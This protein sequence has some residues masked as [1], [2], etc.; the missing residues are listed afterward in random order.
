MAHYQ[1]QIDTEPKSK[2]VDDRLADFCDTERQLQVFEAVKLHGSMKKAANSLGT[3]YDNV[4]KIMRS[5][6]RKAA[7]AGYSPE[8]SMTKTV[9]DGYKVKGVSSLYGQNGELKAQWVKSEQDKERQLEIYTE[10]INSLTADIPERIS[11]PSPKSSNSDLANLYTIT[12]YHIGMLA[13]HK[14][15]GADWDIR[16]AIDTLKSTFTDMFARSP[17]ADTAIINQLG[18]FLHYDSMESVTPTNGHLLDADGRPEKMIK[19]GIEC[20]DYMITEALKTHKKVMVVCAQGNHDTYSSLFM[21]SMFERLYRGEKRVEF[22]SSQLP[23]YAMK[24]GR[25]MIGFHHGHKVKFDNLPAVFADQ[26]REM[27]GSTDRTYI[28]MGHYHHKHIK[29]LGKTVV[30]MHRTLAARDAYA[31]YGGYF[32]QRSADVITYHK[33]KGEC[34]RVTVHV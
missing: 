31:S 11:T 29:E 16:I 10:I 20:M 5:I 6:R 19:A 33:E 8:H 25:S 15:G 4:K 1:E 12:D 24:F 3:T 23:F 7:N 9:P 28:H 14:E 17:D 32:S 22:V 27:Y 26:F 21:R 30:E 34:G 2:V 18:D 13:W